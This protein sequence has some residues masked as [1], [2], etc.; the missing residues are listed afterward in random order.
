M[1]GGHAVQSQNLGIPWPEKPVIHKVSKGD[2]GDLCLKFHLNDDNIQ[3]QSVS[4]N[5][6]D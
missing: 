3:I 2:P 6:D 4:F 5:Q 1:G